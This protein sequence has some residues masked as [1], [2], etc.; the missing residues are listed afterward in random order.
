MTYKTGD[1]HRISDCWINMDPEEI[2]EYWVKEGADNILY[3]SEGGRIPF[4][5]C[6]AGFPSGSVNL[7]PL[8]GN[9]SV[10]RR[11]SLLK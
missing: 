5:Q 6:V 7:E 2:E 3:T 10:E 8:R 9:S 11:I 1:R 4:R